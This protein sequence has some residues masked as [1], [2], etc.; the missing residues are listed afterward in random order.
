LFLEGR[1]DAV[2]AVIDVGAGELHLQAVLMVPTAPVQL[3]VAGGK[4]AAK[5]IG[6]TAT[7]MILI[8]A[9]AAAIYWYCTQPAERRERIKDAAGSLATSYMNEFT[10]GT[11]AVTRARLDLHALL[12]PRPGQRS[13][14]SAVLRELAVA[15]EPLTA[16]QP[17]DLLDE[18][19]RPRVTDLPAF[20]R[21]RHDVHPGPAPRL[22]ARTALPGARRRLPLRQTRLAERPEH[23]FPRAN[24]VWPRKGLSGGH[25]GAAPLPS[26]GPPGV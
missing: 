24:P 17:A 13:V 4:W 25:S 23:E 1:V 8:A 26:A 20:L 14:M 11:E 21:Q 15:P 5:K 2:L 12:V 16:Q 22:R 19:L 18:S 3:T 9:A 10:A 6:P 7:W